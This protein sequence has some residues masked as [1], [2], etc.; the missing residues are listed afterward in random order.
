MTHNKI[1][2]RANTY[3]INSIKNQWVEKSFNFIEYGNI[4]ILIISMEV[5]D[6][7]SPL[8]WYWLL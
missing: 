2:T 4:E 1:N 7:I 3:K 5:R 8:R 6:N